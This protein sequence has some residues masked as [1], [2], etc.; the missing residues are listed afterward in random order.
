MNDYDYNLDNYEV[1]QGCL[2]DWREIP[3][4]DDEG[5]ISSWVPAETLGLQGRYWS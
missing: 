1:A 4:F 2:A 3:T 5:E